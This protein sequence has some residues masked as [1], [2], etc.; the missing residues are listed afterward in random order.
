MKRIEKLRQEA[1]CHEHK[2]D[3]FYYKF[4]SR[5]TENK[6]DSEYDKYA[7]AYFS[8]FSELTPNISNGELIVG[9]IKNNF[10]EFE[11]KEWEET[12]M[13]IARERCTNAGGGQDSHMAIDYDLLLSC[14]INGVI[15][16]IDEYQKTCT[17]EQLKFYSTAKTCLLA[18]IKHSENYAL[19]AE[20]L[21]QKEQ[22]E[23]RKAELLQ[24]AKNCKKVPAQPAESFF[25][26]L[27]SVHF[28]TYC[29]SLNPLRFG[30]QQFQLGRPDR[31]L[32]PGAGEI[33]RVC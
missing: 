9:K 20:T 12:Y 25:E 33:R 30:P 1:L 32:Y 18:I 2:R 21:A 24:I 26:A 3:E 7:D 27:Q 8:A 28:I 31:Y 10:T 5:Y 16:Q 29:L 15:A 13:Q 14:G 23:V 19:L 17:P 4:Y 6:S 22:D 11:R